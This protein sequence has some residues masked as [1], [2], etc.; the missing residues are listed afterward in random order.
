M[1]VCFKTIQI[2]WF[3]DLFIAHPRLDFDGLGGG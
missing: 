1:N 2:G 3:T